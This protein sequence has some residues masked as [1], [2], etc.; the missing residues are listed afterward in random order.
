MCLS[1]GAGKPFC[2]PPSSAIP[3]GASV[4]TLVT[5]AGAK[6]LLTVP[7]ILEEIALLSDQRG[8]N[9][10]RKLDF[11]AF[12]GSILKESITQTLS[13]AR[14]RL[15]NHY[16]AT[17]T[18][19]LTPFFQPSP[20]HDWRF[21]QLRTD[22][23]EPLK[24]Q[25]D[26]LDEPDRQGSA[27]KL[28]MQPFG[29][30]ERYEL[31]DMLIRNPDGSGNSFTAAGRTDD[32]ICLATGEKVRPTILEDLLQ[33]N[34]GVKAA[35]AFG[36]NQFELGV[37]VEPMASL[38][39]S[40][41]DAFKASIW[42]AI[43]E[44]GHQMDAHGRISSQAAIIIVD[45]MALPRSDKGTVF[46][47]E[48]YKSFVKEILDVYHELDVDAIAPPID[49]TSPVSSIKSMITTI[50]PCSV[51]NDDWSEEKRPIRARNGQSPGDKIT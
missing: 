20:S 50:L 2:I 1:L 22:I 8:I 7:S 44:A 49:L 43:E 16:G 9:A 24:V 10:L 15:I 36:N 51:V 14:V 21:F 37:V 19:P 38:T 29:W 47:N 6:A 23:I 46:R 34:E 32:L 45:R 39:P 26:P 3:T 5:D 25:L 33:Q 28:S 11:V 35:T 17:E 12:E 40:E 31:R 42:P 4:T 27:F 41:H 13:S 30:N 48:V 18:R